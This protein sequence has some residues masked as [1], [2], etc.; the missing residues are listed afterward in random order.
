MGPAPA[1]GCSRTPAGSRRDQLRVQER[2]DDGRR[3]RQ[4]LADRAARCASAA[5]LPDPRPLADLADL[6]VMVG[7]VPVTATKWSHDRPPIWWCRVF[8]AASTVGVAGFLVCARGDTAD[9]LLATST[10]RP[11]LPPACAA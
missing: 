6:R 4:R 10:V 5:A 9:V 11:S 3:P 8:P 7:H 2:L 1:Y